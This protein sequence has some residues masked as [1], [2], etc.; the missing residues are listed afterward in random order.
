[1]SEE[2]AFKTSHSGVIQPLF[3]KQ[4]IYA[5]IDCVVT[6]PN[7]KHSDHRALVAAQTGLFIVKVKKKAAKIVHFISILDVTRLDVPAQDSLAV[8]TAAATWTFSSPDIQLI[9]NDFLRIHSY[10]SYGNEEFGKALKLPNGVAYPECTS[11]PRHLTTLRYRV[12]SACLGVEISAGLLG[13]FAEF[14]RTK[15]TYISFKDGDELPFRVEQIWYP[16]AFDNSLTVLELVGYAGPIVG[17]IVNEIMMRSSSMTTVVMHNYSELRFDQIQFGEMVEPKVVSFHFKNVFARDPRESRYFLEELGHYSGDLQQLTLSGMIWDGKG[18]DFFAMS[19]MTDRCYQSLEYLAIEDCICAENDLE[20]VSKPLFS[21]AQHLQSLYRFSMTGWK[22]PVVFASDDVKHST[23]L[24]KACNSLR[25]C[26]L[27][28]LDFTG[29]KGDIALPSTVVDI[30]FPNCAFRGKTLL[31][32]MK[33]KHSCEAPLTFVLNDIEMSDE[34]WTV[35]WESLNEVEPFTNIAELDWSG[36]EFKNNSERTFTEK[37]ISSTTRFL[38]LSRCCKKGQTEPILYI[39]RALETSHIWGIQ[40]R[41]GNTDELQLQDDMIPIVQALANVVSL[42]HLDICHQ[43]MSDLCVRQLVDIFK[44]MKLLHEIAMDGTSLTWLS[45]CGCYHH[46]RRDVSVRGLLAPVNDLT[47]T[48]CPELLSSKYYATLMERL[49]HTRSITPRHVRVRMYERTLSLD[50]EM[51][52]FSKIWPVTCQL[53]FDENPWGLTF[54]DPLCAALRTPSD[55]EM[56]PITTSF[57]EYLNSQLPDP[58]TSPV[59]SG[60]VQ[61]LKL[62][63]CLRDADGKDFE[64]ED[65]V[66]W[67]SATFLVDQALKKSELLLTREF[68][69]IWQCLDTIAA[70]FAKFDN[71][72]DSYS[73]YGKFLP[74]PETYITK[75]EMSIVRNKCNQLRLADIANAEAQEASESQPWWGDLPEDPESANE[76]VSRR[77]RLLSAGSSLTPMVNLHLAAPVPVADT[78]NVTGYSPQDMADIAESYDAQTKEALNRLCAIGETLYA[79]APGDD[80]ECSIFGGLPQSPEV[81]TTT[82]APITDPMYLQLCSVLL[83]PI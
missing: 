72:T 53:E 9:L 21:V 12:I 61:K 58:Y 41:G 69:N 73:E 32:I 76:I 37:F 52:G 59:S 15:R 10:L 24:I 1:M 79:M 7:H 78:E 33:T 13:K 16:L 83:S 6:G 22:T 5:A 77:I 27:G 28:N 23:L 48:S 2:A 36:N 45:L 39:I 54:V 38:S 25:S 26:V 80:E 66:F 55:K 70:I 56:P 11:M 4:H 82:V 19:V 44:E 29:M 68:A 62:P 63:K 18:A 34:E 40:I 60:Q 71:C 42:E 47:R 43:M 30:E 35:F 81:N 64:V 46:I 8:F 74:K 14:D 49:R 3:K 75:K 50:E 67:N 57:A 17:I 51:A 20:S 65:G 31:N